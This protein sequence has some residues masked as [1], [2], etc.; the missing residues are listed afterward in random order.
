MKASRSWQ[1]IASMLAVGSLIAFF[2]L[3]GG[4]LQ[5]QRQG[6]RAFSRDPTGVSAVDQQTLEEN[7]EIGASRKEEGQSVR[8]TVGG[9]QEPDF[10]EV[11]P[12]PSAQP[13][14]PFVIHVNDT[15]ET[16]L[17]L[18]AYPEPAR[19]SGIQ[20]RVS[21]IQASRDGW[22]TSVREVTPADA[23]TRFEIPIVPRLAVEGLVL[24][25]E[26]G[27]PVD[28]FA[29]RIEARVESVRGTHVVV[30]SGAEF[31]SGDGGFLV[32]EET[33]DVVAERITISAPGRVTARSPWKPVEGSLVIFEPM[34]LSKCD[35]C[36]IFGIVFDASGAPI[37]GAR[38]LI[39]PGSA[40]PTV[41]RT[42]KGPV[43]R[44]VGPFDNLEAGMIDE[45]GA[46]VVESS[47]TADGSFQLFAPCGIQARLIV[48]AHGYVSFIGELETLSGAADRT[49]RVFLTAASPASIQLL[50]GEHAQRTVH[51]DRVV[52]RQ[53]GES[54]EAQVTN[55][56]A[57]IP[58]VTTLEAL[59][60]P[61][62]GGRVDVYG[63][64]IG[65]AI[66]TA[67]SLPIASVRFPPNTRYPIIV[68]LGVDYGGA[69]ITAR[70]VLP[71]EVRPELCIVAVYD[72]LTGNQVAQGHVA[73]DGTVELH[74]LD[75]G[76]LELVL[77]GYGDQARTPLLWQQ[78]IIVNTGTST[79]LGTVDLSKQGRIEILDC[80]AT[81][82]RITSDQGAVSPLAKELLV[83]TNPIDSIIVLGLPAGRY[84][85][86][87]AQ[88]GS[89]WTFVR[90]GSDHQST[91][92]TPL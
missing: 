10:I 43:V 40:A 6:D 78:S 26:D 28:R 14:G 79:A 5:S 4:G 32:A 68:N 27:Q 74:E 72:T 44:S 92:L 62:A 13:W 35:D 89:R 48:A 84:F 71:V 85:A 21:R 69:F 65:R 66:D 38:V 64:R 46:P 59:I 22:V 87:P 15:S 51:V 3:Q 47:T 19:F 8:E 81:V 60:S 31:V 23:E 36:T 45:D 1:L 53:S 16:Q 63:R 24:Q 39:S 70:F 55:E 91:V 12:R 11:A 86:E 73:D 76:E 7:R 30:S 57:G 77:L 41:Y 9:T 52:V 42:P 37:S 67:A 75:A 82:W 2:T 83:R 88:G 20:G 56:L 49:R 54:A 58:S 33:D 50:M 61:S 18:T 90:N 34:L 29:V 17:T 25:A 80:P